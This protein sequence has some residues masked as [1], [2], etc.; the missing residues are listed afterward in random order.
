MSPANHVLVP[1]GLVAVLTVRAIAIGPFIFQGTQFFL[2][3][4]YGVSPYYEF[5]DYI[6]VRG[7]RRR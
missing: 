7:W 4:L 3:P 6:E 1:H 2:E 5:C